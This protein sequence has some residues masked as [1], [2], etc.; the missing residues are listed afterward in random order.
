MGD[1]SQELFSDPPTSN[2]MPVFNGVTELVDLVEQLTRRPKWGDTPSEPVSRRESRVRRGLPLL[3]LIRTQPHDGLLPALGDK[4]ATAS[5]SRIPHAYLRLNEEFGT[6][7]RTRLTDHDPLD[8]ADV[9]VLRALLLAVAAELSRSVN[10]RWGRF[11]FPALF[12]MTGLM[13]QD[14]DELAEPGERTSKLRSW[15]RQRDI[16]SRLENSLGAATSVPS[17][18]PTWLGWVARALRL[19]PPLLFAAKVTGRAP[20]LSGIY[21]WFLRQPYLSPQIP[22]DFIGFA[23]RL[24]A[25]EWA[26]EDPEQVARLLVNALLEDLRR[27]YRWRPWQLRGKRRSTYTALLLDNITRANGGYTLLR[28]INSVRNE[29]GRFDP[30]LVISA[31]RKVPPSAVE[32]G[33]H[34]HKP[35]VYNA[36]KAAVGHGHWRD[37]LANDRRARRST[38]W[39]LRVLVPGAPTGEQVEELRQTFRPRERYV[40]P[41]APWL[42]SRTTRVLLVVALA[43]S[44][45]V[46]A[47][48]WTDHR[49][50]D[51][52]ALPWYSLGL[53]RT[54]DG[55]AGVTDGSADIFEPTSGPLQFRQVL[56][57]VL[58]N[59]R[60]AVQLHADHPDWPYLT[61]VNMQA[62]TAADDKADSLTAQREGLEGVAVA[63][64]AQLTTASRTEP[65]VRV[66]IANAGRNMLQGPAVA[67][68]LGRMAVSD[69]SIGGVVGL[70]MSSK[71]TQDTI[72]ALTTA[73]LPM[74]ASTLSAD[75]LV[76][77]NPLYFQV[78]P[79]NRREAAFAAEFARN[80]GAVPHGPGTKVRVYYTAD[81]QDTYSTNLADDVATAFTDRNFVVDKVQY[82]PAGKDGKPAN[83][84]GRDTCGFRGIVYFAG[85]G[86]PDFQDFLNGAQQCEVTATYLAGDDVTRYVADTAKRQANKAVPFYYV[87]FSVANESK[88]A[89]GAPEGTNGTTF[90]LS[91]QFGFE[92][93]DNL[94]SRS[95]DGHAALSF[96][97]TR[98]LISAARYLAQHDIPIT[99][100]GLW[101]EIGLINRATDL[102]DQGN[103]ALAGVTGDID[104]GGSL[105]HHV[106]QNKAI[107]MLRVVS[108]EVVS[109]VVAACPAEKWCPQDNGR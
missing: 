79:Q 50:G 108:G 66:L 15:L 104:F 88:A 53:T 55:C 23:E 46:G 43:A 12:L 105:T 61:L 21:R 97:A 103:T 48:Q 96:D 19:L 49:C 37:S 72:D 8:H 102:A 51:W 63:Q 98:V 74:V 30:L 107:A 33:D 71:P 76:D 86:V 39:Y 101:R 13:E 18:G 7:T 32:P 1:N 67:A 42:V 83:A 4:L 17:D 90:G 68:Q 87:S 9:E 26:R 44:A 80:T 16:T 99:P 85:R 20:G 45:A 94:A 28:M 6:G 22:G 95:L 64:R 38:A 91:D 62:F 41:P 2:E 78:A 65:I 56:D 58:A 40:V 36:D 100:A 77:K 106:P 109:K 60:E 52:G 93:P 75:S 59:N 31:S 82:D 89:A 57:A 35:V 81:P 10:S 14:L 70:D 24:T 73:G 25:G 92:S 69:P 11:R 34:T 3:C 5:P 27:S 54:V 84:A 47:W 29:I